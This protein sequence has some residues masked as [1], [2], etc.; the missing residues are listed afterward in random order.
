MA[1]VARTSILTLGYA[2][3]A[4]APHINRL[5]IRALH[6]AYLRRYFQLRP[7]GEDEYQRWFPVIAAARLNENVPGWDN[8]LLA[9][10]M[11]LHQN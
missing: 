3:L 6:K 5:V 10:A 1:D 7:G 2:N 4:S 9:Q 8:W 11:G